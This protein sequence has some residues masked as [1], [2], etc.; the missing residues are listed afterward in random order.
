MKYTYKTDDGSIRTVDI[1]DAELV[2]LGK[3][4]GSRDINEC[5]EL[6]LFDHGHLDNETVD[7]LTAKAKENKCGA[8]AA[9]N[10]QKKPRKPRDPDMVKRALMSYLLNAVTEIPDAENIKVENPERIIAFE[11][12]DEMYNITLSRKRK[13]KN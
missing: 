11:Y 3:S 12:R 1:P 8:K 7:E 13:P 4:I 9:G 2:A 6:W 10:K 5:V